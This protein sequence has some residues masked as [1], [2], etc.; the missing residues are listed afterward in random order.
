MLDNQMSDLA[1]LMLRKT[2]IFSERNRGKPELGNLTITL[3]VGVRRFTLVGTEENK[4]I[5]A[6]L[7]N[8]R[9][10]SL[11]ITHHSSLITHYSF[12][13]RLAQGGQMAL[14]YRRVFDGSPLLVNL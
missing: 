5:R 8:S 1:Y 9:H 7:E 11:I 14:Q 10:G 13:P 2:S 12:K 3:D 6:V 4:T